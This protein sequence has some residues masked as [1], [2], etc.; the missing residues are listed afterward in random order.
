MSSYPSGGGLVRF[1]RILGIAVEKG[2]GGSDA[3]DWGS[4]LRRCAMSTLGVS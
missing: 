3:E 2:Q 1:V 4:K